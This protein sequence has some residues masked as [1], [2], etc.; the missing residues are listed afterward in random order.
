MLPAQSQQAAGGQVSSLPNSLAGQQSSA[1]RLCASAPEQATGT[2]IDG[3]EIS[4]EEDVDDAAAHDMDF[5]GDDGDINFNQSLGQISSSCRSLFDQKSSQLRTFRSGLGD[6]SADAPGASDSALGQS[7]SA[8]THSSQQTESQKKG[9]CS[10]EQIF[11]QKKM[12]TTAKVA[13]FY[14]T[15]VVKICCYVKEFYGSI[16]TL[17]RN[18]LIFKKVENALRDRILYPLPA[19]VKLVDLMALSFFQRNQDSDFTHYCGSDTTPLTDDMLAF[20]DRLYNN[21]FG[22]VRKV[23]SNAV[24]SKFQALVKNITGNGKKSGQ[25]SLRSY[26]FCIF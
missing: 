14:T 21:K 15:V 25:G 4:H 18:T 13:Q 22:D 8:G 3:C 9:D 23:L 16:G 5:F 2:A 11:E 19:D 12:K 1:A 17:R 10:T 7:Q 6:A 24:I 20:A 26:A